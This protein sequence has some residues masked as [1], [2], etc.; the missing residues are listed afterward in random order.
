[1]E[2]AKIAEAGETLASQL[3]MEE[4]IKDVMEGAFR[5][6]RPLLHSHKT[7]TLLLLERYQSLAVWAEP[8]KC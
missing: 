8:I 2:I 4:I 6:F 3:G 7:D 5:L 1:V